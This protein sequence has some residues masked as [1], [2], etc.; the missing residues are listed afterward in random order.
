MKIILASGS[1]RRRELLSQIGLEYEVKVSDVDETTDAE[2]PYM[3]VEDLSRKK[4]K[5]VY[6]EVISSGECFDD[7]LIVIGADTLVA[8][9][10]EILGKP[11]DI[12]SAKA[13]LCKLNGRKHD[14]FTGVTLHGIDKNGGEFVK[15][16]N[17]KTQVEF[18]E[19]TDEEIDTY[20]ATGDPMDKAGAYG[21][22]GFAARYIKG[23][24]GDYNNVVGLPVGRLY[25]E[26]KDYL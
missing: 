3:I 19:M 15:I 17:E 14:V 20:I 23:I 5:A 16:F 13:V 6:E 26:M 21:I 25:Q 1:P 18:A 12:T 9:D 8:V 22:Q 2:L 7:A 24:D 10:N 4:A 11:V